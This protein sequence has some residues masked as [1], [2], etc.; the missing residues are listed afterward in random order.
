MSNPELLLGITNIRISGDA[1]R[2]IATYGD[3]YIRKF[4]LGM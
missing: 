2:I 4:S 3:D 1:T